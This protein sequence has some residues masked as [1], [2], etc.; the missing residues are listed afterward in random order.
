MKFRRNCP[1]GFTLPE[2]LFSMTIG[3]M[4]L[5][6]AASMLGTSGESYERVGANIASER[7]ARA[8]ITQ[9]S[10]DL[11]TGFFHEDGLIQKD[12]SLW[13]KDQIGFLCLKPE[14]AQ[15]KNEAIGDLCA[16]HYYI[17]DRVI[18]GKITR[19]LMRGFRNSSETFDK[20]KNDTVT[21]LFVPPINNSDEPIA[22]GVMSFSVNPKALDN[23]GRQIDWDVTLNPTGPTAFTFR[24]VLAR[25][26]LAAK[27]RTTS[28][29]DGGFKL[30]GLPEKAV[31]NP[32]LEIYETTLR[33]GN[34]GKL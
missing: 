27:L 23:S 32:G 20:L 2:L 29:W 33:F 16:V 1:A 21:E 11:S 26:D 14:E 22:F 6:L 5:M 25:R 15:S 31:E 24:L 18:A 8:L 3:A 34:H 17:A 28:D 9:L 19:C 10:S 12:S 4:V 30:I 13:A 7:E